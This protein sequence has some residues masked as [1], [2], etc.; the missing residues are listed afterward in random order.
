MVVGDKRL[1]DQFWWDLHAAEPTPEEFAAELCADLE[2]DACHGASVAAA[3]RI[4]VCRHECRGHAACDDMGCQ[5]PDCT[6][7]DLKQMSNPT[8]GFRVH[9]EL[10]VCLRV[11]RTNATGLKAAEPADSFC[12]ALQLAKLRRAPP[13]CL[14]LPTPRIAE[15]AA[16]AAQLVPEGDSMQSAYTSR[17]A[18]AAAAAAAVPPSSPLAM[19]LKIRHAAVF[20][21]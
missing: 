17:Q 16:S 12:P 5:A 9:E 14:Q 4:E 2:L 15:Q 21:V 10:Q 7:P 20:A 6:V 11:L 8:V 1:R 18:A 19:H 13:T 3:I